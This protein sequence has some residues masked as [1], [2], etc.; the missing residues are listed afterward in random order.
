MPGT[1]GTVDLT[2]ALRRLTPKTTGALSTGPA[3][4]SQNGFGWRTPDSIMSTGSRSALSSLNSIQYPEK[5]KVRFDTISTAS[6]IRWW[7]LFF[8]NV[9]EYIP[10][11]CLSS[12]YCVHLGVYAHFRFYFKSFSSLHNP[13]KPDE[14]QFQSHFLILFVFFE[15]RSRKERHLFRSL[16]QLFPWYRYRN[17]SFFSTTFFLSLPVGFW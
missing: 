11:S 3:A 12:I 7:F 1:P 5:L 17:F 14:W 4:T 16:N 2:N 8:F 6:T 15:G 10:S 9:V 13:E